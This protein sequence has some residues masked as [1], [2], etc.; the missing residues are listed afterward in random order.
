MLH[1]DFHTVESRRLLLVSTDAS[2]VAAVDA[3]TNQTAWRHVLPG[4]ER[5]VSQVLHTRAGQ[6]LVGS[7]TPEGALMAR[8]W[9]VGGALLWDA[10]VPAPPPSA[11]VHKP[12]ASFVGDSADVLALCG[13]RVHVLRGRSGELV[14]SWEHAPATTGGSV[15]TWQASSLSADQRTLAIHG[16]ATGA[17]DEARGPS[18]LARADLEVTNGA[19]VGGVKLVAAGGGID[20]E[21][22]LLLTLEPRFAVA[23]SK[24]GDRLLFAA[25]PDDGSATAGA[26]S[27]FAVPHSRQ[28]GGDGRARLLPVAL[29]GAVVVA[30]S[31]AQHVLLDLSQAAP[32]P[33][34][35][36]E[37]TW[38]APGA[39]GGLR[40]GAQ[41][42]LACAAPSASGD[43]LEQATM[44]VTAGSVESLPSP[45][46]ARVDFASHGAP[47]ALFLGSYAKRDS[48]IAQRALLVSA[49]GAAHYAVD[50]ACAWTR[51]EALAH[52]EQ[53]EFVDLPRV[54]DVAALEQ[55]PQYGSLF[56]AL[57][58]L[59]GGGAAALAAA[60]GLGARRHSP[61]LTSDAFGF[62]KLMVV[63]TRSSKI[64]AL[65]SLDGSPVW[66][67][68][69]T[70]DGA[71]VTVHTLTVVPAPTSQ[72]TDIALVVSAR[73]A[74]GADERYA[75]IT[76]DA[77]KGEQ[78]GDAHP[79][80]QRVLWT[81]S[82]GTPDAA[83]PGAPPLPLLALVHA[84]FS[85]SL[86]PETS[87]AARA[88]EAS[89]RG[90]MHFFLLDRAE[91]VIKGYG[92]AAR[93]EGGGAAFAAVHRWS[94]APPPNARG[95][96]VCTLDSAEA[97]HSPVRVLGDRGVLHKY[98]NPN[99]LAVG[100]T[101][102]GRGGAAGSSSELSVHVTVL[103]G[104][105]GA[106]VH[107]FVTPRAAGPLRLAL[108]ENTL[109]AYARS[110]ATGAPFVSVTE[111]YENATAPN[112]MRMLL[113]GARPPRAH[114]GAPTRGVLARTA[115]ERRA[116]A[117]SAPSALG[118]PPS[119]CA[120]LRCAAARRLRPGR[121]VCAL[122]V[123]A[124]R[125]LRALGR[126]LPARGRGGG[127][128][129]AD[130]QGHHA[131]PRHVRAP[132]RTA[133]GPGERARATRRTRSAARAR[134]RLWCR[135][136]ADRSAQRGA[137]E[138]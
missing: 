18:Q 86:F 14:W 13:A 87:E 1:A 60:S 12:T 28:G 78:R 58:S 130:H 99:L 73:G 21:Q 104:V 47:A 121:R 79:L 111:L 90:A 4:G 39:C 36:W 64:V 37:R 44:L 59:A 26:A 3:A 35:A 31:P 136:R 34:V 20:A 103:D 120:A 93:R 51:D 97:V 88:F 125:A 89:A 9:T 82:V 32:E 29:P 95:L 113:S 91:G 112:Y 96:S 71:P 43:A 124:A 53:L 7:V 6:L 8:L 135:R 49:T 45:P 63:R 72:P 123:R 57:G 66:G 128:H 38:S 65:S 132:Q 24:A 81:I 100:Y 116:I 67:T 102:T 11:A 117:Q 105:S 2:I 76:I 5:V 134:A 55:G 122:R 84:D 10:H 40:S 69:P 101:Q 85:V 62:N 17:R 115:A 30:P 33:H 92:L 131:A 52:V 126:V 119:A 48:A 138:P 114:T 61:E 56:R 107:D 98:L 137:P 110:A 109:V 94:F 106:A 27:S 133:A 23:V 68:L 22:G 46:A 54:R 129:H 50:G 70:L 127:G 74:D 77:L 83:A 108:S 75:L 15:I 80:P 25:A 41:A 42:I 19:L 16:L 118:P